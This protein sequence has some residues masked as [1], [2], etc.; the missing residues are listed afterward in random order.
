M[1]IK[2]N[3]IRVLVITG[4]LFLFT[5]C[6]GRVKSWRVLDRHS[7][8]VKILETNNWLNDRK[9][10]YPIINNL[11][12]NQLKFFIDTDMRKYDRLDPAFELYK[13]SI[14]NIDSILS[15]FDNMIKSI[16]INSSKLQSHISNKEVKSINL[17]NQIDEK[18]KIIEREI[19]I[20][21][22]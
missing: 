7:L 10:E 19:K 9:K 17:K 6:A 22:I 20:I 1:I 18:S 15:D 4:T 21:T 13:E 12:R 16:P 5:D 8:D 11:I 2:L 14:N 3:I